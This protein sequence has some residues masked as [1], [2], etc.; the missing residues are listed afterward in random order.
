MSVFKKA[1][2]KWLICTAKRSEF[3]K[4]I[5]KRVH[6]ESVSG[7]VLAQAAAS[8]KALLAREGQLDYLGEVEQLIREFEGMSLLDFWKSYAIG[9][10]A[11]HYSIPY[12]GYE[13]SKFPCDLFIYPDI[14]YRYKPDV[15]VEI[16]TQRGSSAIYF[17]DLI[18]AHKGRVVT[19]DIHPPEEEM[20]RRLS[21]KGIA[22]LKGDINAPEIIESVREY[23]NC[24]DCLIVDD[25]SHRQDDVFNA[26]RLLRPLVPK[27]GF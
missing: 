5:A 3:L 26:F 19:I 13:M 10:D 22:F 14:I 11:P 16:G 9:E 27:G 6:A 17:S 12:K 2:A 8:R 20:L 24:K 21:E 18:A 23:C 1:L 15:I 4:S 25:G 7:D